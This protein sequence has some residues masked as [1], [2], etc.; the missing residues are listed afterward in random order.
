MHD[1]W[2][3]ARLSLLGCQ[4]HLKEMA[5]LGKEEKQGQ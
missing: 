2:M 3:A 4:A 5:P 1:W